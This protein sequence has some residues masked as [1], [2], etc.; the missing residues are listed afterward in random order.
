LSELSLNGSNPTPEELINIAK[1]QQLEKL[2]IR[3]CFNLNDT[4]CAHLAKNLRNLTVS[5]F[6]YYSLLEKIF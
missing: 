2:S 4:V 1:L 5:Q 3:L 6:K